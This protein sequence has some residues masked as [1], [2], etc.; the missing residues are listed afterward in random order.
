MS[1]S[2]ENTYTERVETI[3]ATTSSWPGGVRRARFPRAFCVSKLA[4]NQSG[5]GPQSLGTLLSCGRLACVL[6]KCTSLR[7]LLG[8]AALVDRTD[9]LGPG[10]LTRTFRAD[11]S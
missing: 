2:S 11:D 10:S 4:N 7:N 6:E 1:M 5:T 3:V 9:P 8:S